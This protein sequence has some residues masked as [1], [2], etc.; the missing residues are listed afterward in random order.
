MANVA[1]NGR[2]IRMLCWTLIF[3]GEVS[4]C[5]EKHGSASHCDSAFLSIIDS[6]HFEFN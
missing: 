1:W 3:P 6:K 2:G 4:I 5:T